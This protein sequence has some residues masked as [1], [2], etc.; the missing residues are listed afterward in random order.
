MFG[1]ILLPVVVYFPTFGQNASSDSLLTELQLAVSDSAKALVYLKYA[2]QIIS[3][4]PVKALEYL[5]K[6]LELVPSAGHSVHAQLLVELGKHQR[7]TGDYANAIE[8]FLFALS[9]FENPKL[10]PLDTAQKRFYLQKIADCHNNLAVA[11]FMTNNT[12][13]VEKALNNA[14]SIYKQLN[15]TKSIAI[16]LNNIGEIYQKRGIPITA[17]QY[18]KQAYD[19]ALAN[20]DVRM[21]SILMNNFGDTNYNLGKYSRAIFFQGR[22]L[23]MAKELKDIEGIAYSYLGLAKA[24][25]KLFNYDSALYCA[26]QGLQIAKTNNINYL[27]KDGLL[28]LK[29]IYAAQKNFQKSALYADSLI[30]LLDTLYTQD[31]NKLI[32][33]SQLRYELGKQQSQIELLEKENIIQQ[34]KLINAELH[35]NIVYL[36]VSSAF[37]I[38]SMLLYFLH[39]RQINNE[40]LL[41]SNQ[42]LDTKNKE[43]KSL[44]ETKDK[45][46]SI[47]AH[48]LRAPLSALKNVLDLVDFKLLTPQEFEKLA[49]DIR[50]NLQNILYTLNNLLEWSYLQIKSGSSVNPEVYNVKEIIYET[51]NF[52][53][54]VARQKQIEIVANVPPS[55]SVKADKNHLRFVLRNLLNNA[56]KFSHPQSQI[57]IQASNV[58]NNQIEIS[59]TDYGLG[60]EESVKSQLFSPAMRPTEGTTGEKGTGLGLMLCKEFIEKNNGQI[61]VES[62]VGKGSTFKIVLWNQ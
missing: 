26:H 27:I 23:K 49:I 25:H 59:I 60:I 45:L 34:Q 19:I 12:E 18:Y 51:I 9:I 32:N 7:L 56:I 44:N 8:N 61:F 17:L 40:K 41:S 21:Q 31:K 10:L 53:E 20:R 14:L 16:V 36:V 28:T 50:K 24:Y 55:A 48:D 33:Q 58:S 47:I 46:F 57:L 3:S 15:D 11:Y 54:E 42:V 39:Q 5:H 1:W 29:S 30:F 62:Q 37:I 52:Y 4:E 38:I 35:R 2:K 6:G 13:Q 43:L 22:A